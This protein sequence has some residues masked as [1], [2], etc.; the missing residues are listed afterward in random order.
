MPCWVCFRLIPVADFI[1]NVVSFG[2]RC[3]PSGSHACL[4][5]VL[6]VCDFCASFVDVALALQLRCT[7]IG[8]RRIFGLFGLLCA[9]APSSCEARLVVAFG[10]M[11]F[12]CVFWWFVF[13]L[14]RCCVCSGQ[15]V[16][17]LFGLFNVCV[18]L[19][20]LYKPFARKPRLNGLP[21]ACT[22]F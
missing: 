4:F 15:F 22:S 3:S 20:R 10:Q 14:R 16:A 2:L 11:R 5:R 8:F 17:I 18:L 1:A 19:S 13:C 12:V 21:R 6:H 9:A 7:P